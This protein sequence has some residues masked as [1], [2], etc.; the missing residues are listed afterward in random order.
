MVGHNPPR[1][2]GAASEVGQGPLA[3]QLGSEPI[4]GGH[5]APAQLHPVHEVGSQVEVPCIV[6]GASHVGAPSQVVEPRQVADPMHVRRSTPQVGVPSHDGYSGQVMFPEQVCADPAQVGSAVQ[7]TGWHV[8]IAAQ[9]ACMQVK[10]PLQVADPWHDGNPTMV[11][12]PQSGLDAS[13]VGGGGQV[14]AP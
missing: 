2:L 11:G 10:K 4:V 14:A 5:C 7:V 8:S 1:Q 12:S 6:G 3:G 13:Y 9:V